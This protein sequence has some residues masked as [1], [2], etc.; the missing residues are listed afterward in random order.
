MLGPTPWLM[1]VGAQAGIGDT[2]ENHNL[3]TRKT[4][5][6]FW[7]LVAILAILWLLG[8]L[9][10]TTMGGLIHILLVVALVLII[11]NLLS[12]RRRL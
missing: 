1:G 6:M 12:G 7:T 10:S 11:V 8:L 5:T 3:T 9:T 2:N 4:D